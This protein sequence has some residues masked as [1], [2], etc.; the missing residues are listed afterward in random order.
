[1]DHI[2]ALPELVSI[3]EQRKIG[4]EIIIHKNDSMFLGEDSFSA[5]CATFAAATGG[6]DDFV[7]DIWQ[8]MPCATRFMEEGDVIGRFSVIHLPGHTQG[9]VALYDAKNARVFS[10]DTLFRGTVGRTDLPESSAALLKKSLARILTLPGGT[11]VFSGHGGQT[12]I[13]DEKALFL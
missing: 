5:H 3:F 13:E 12:S 8:G 4:L 2:A 6:S 7:R 1:L 9:S 11:T 10:G